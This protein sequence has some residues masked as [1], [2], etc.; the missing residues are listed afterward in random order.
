[1]KNLQSL[2]YQLLTEDELKEVNGGFICGGW[3]IA[4]II[5]V[6]VSVGAFAVGVYNGYNEEAAAAAAA[7][8]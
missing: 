1:M 5:V 2:E 6:V 7:A 3:C 4:G 8:K